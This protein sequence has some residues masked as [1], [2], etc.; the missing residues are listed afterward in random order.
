MH[1]RSP[2]CIEHE[3]RP[4]G[5][6][7]A[8]GRTAVTSDVEVVDLTG[9][10]RMGGERKPAWGLQTE[11]LNVNLI[12]LEAGGAIAEHTNTE[13]DVLLVV[14]EGAGTVEVDGRRHDL[15]Q[16]QALVV[17]KGARRSIRCTGDSFVY[18]TCHRRRAGLWPAGIPA[19]PQ[20][21]GPDRA[22]RLEEKRLPG[23]ATRQCRALRRARTSGADVGD[24]LE[25]VE[26]EGRSQSDGESRHEE[27]QKLL[28]QPLPPRR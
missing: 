2:W 1:W 19:R 3:T 9:L 28:D 23:P 25:D 14:V 4:E 13:V 11:D 24:L 21:A 5:R 22:E 10:A 16:G 20:T 27:A 7:L 26:P 15:R 18:L 8:R 6:D 17:P 12:V